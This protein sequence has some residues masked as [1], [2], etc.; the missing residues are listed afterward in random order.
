MDA[1]PLKLLMLPRSRRRRCL[2]QRPLCVLLFLLA[3]TI[4]FQQRL[5]FPHRPFLRIPKR[6]PATTSSSSAEFNN[7]STSDEPTT[8]TDPNED[9]QLSEVNVAYKSRYDLTYDPTEE[10]YRSTQRQRSARPRLL[11]W[12]SVAFV[13]AAVTPEYYSFMRW[14]ILQRFVNANLNVFGTQCLVLSLGVATSHAQLGALSA[15]LQWVLKDALGKVVRMAW[16]SKMGSRMDSDAKRWRMRSAFSYGLGNF[17]EISTYMVPQFFLLLAALSNCCKQVSMLT[18]SSTR[19]AIFNTFR[20]GSG[21]NI[22][23]ISAKGEAQ[24]AIVDLVGLATGV[25]LSKAVVGTSI[26]AILSIY[27]ILQSLELACVYRQ[28]RAVKFRVLNFERMMTLVTAYCHGLQ[29]PSPTEMAKSERMFRPPNLLFRRQVAF[30]SLGRS[31]LSPNELK[32]LLGIFQSERFLLMVGANVKRPARQ[33]FK[34]HRDLLQENCHIVLHSEASNGDIVKSTLAL[35]VLRRRLVESSLGPAAVR[36]SDCYDLIQESLDEANEL[37]G[38]F[39][40]ETSK[41]GWESPSKSMFGRVRMRAEW[42]RGGS[43]PKQ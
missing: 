16:A 29:M 35:H 18:S 11:S 34:S 37:F 2:C 12:L 20:D 22:G 1:G 30:G 5:A 26:H 41:R 7:K 40:R 32:R 4:A 33:F 36:C 43:M 23:D 10:R 8:K 27:A 3:R 25:T 38:A 15:A 42:P 24:V 13:P 31:K 17:L 14:R 9:P 21:E 39:F 19:S 28:L 6:R